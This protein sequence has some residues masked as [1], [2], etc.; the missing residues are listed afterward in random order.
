MQIPSVERSTP[1]AKHAAVR[2]NSGRTRSTV[3]STE[4]S[5]E[6]ACF[7]KIWPCEG[8]SRSSGRRLGPTACG[9]PYKPAEEAYGRDNWLCKGESG[10]RRRDSNPRHADYDRRQLLRISLVLAEFCLV[11]SV[12]LGLFLPSR[13]HI[14]GH[15]FKSEIGA[16]LV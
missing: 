16:P 3:R 6:E 5:D 7:K 11:R 12:Q 2:L 8:K 4:K 15:I 9:F 10:C 13:G 1:V 14:S